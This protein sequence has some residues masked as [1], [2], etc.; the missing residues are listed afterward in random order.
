MTDLGGALLQQHHHHHHH[1]SGG[2]REVFGGSG[3]GYLHLARALGVRGLGE[4][5][6]VEGGVLHPTLS[7]RLRQLLGDPLH[8]L[9]RDL[10]PKVAVERRRCPSLPKQRKGLHDRLVSHREGFR[11]I[12]FQIKI[13]RHLNDPTSI[14]KIQGFMF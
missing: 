3:E 13:D 14:D 9:G 7:E 12:D 11:N 5:G 10:G 8:G 2:S 4:R 6:A 1:V